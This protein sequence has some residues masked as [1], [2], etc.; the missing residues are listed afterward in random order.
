MRLVFCSDPLN[1]RQPD[2]AYQAEAAA[3]ERLGIPFPLVDHD[4]LAHDNDPAKAVRRVPP[5]PDPGLGLYRGWM[6][7]PEQY[8]L[9]YEALAAKG[10]R[11]L[12]DPAAYRHCHYL[13]ESYPAIEPHTPRSAWIKTRGDVS[14]D[15]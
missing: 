2:E 4:A 14:T 9:M 7:T 5:Q 13:P 8:R 10:L 6:L 15:E 12:N 11:L 1:P 3:A